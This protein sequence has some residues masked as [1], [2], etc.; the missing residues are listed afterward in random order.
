MAFTFMEGIAFKLFAHTKIKCAFLTV[1]FLCADQ[2][3]DLQIQICKPCWNSYIEK[4]KICAEDGVFC[5]KRISK[6][7]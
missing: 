6:H 7:F 1:V 4:K 2:S 3:M 5:R